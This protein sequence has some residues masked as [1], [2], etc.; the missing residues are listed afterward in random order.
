MFSFTKF[1]KQHST[2]TLRRRKDKAERQSEE[3]ESKA[4]PVHLEVEN[5]V[6]RTRYVVLLMVARQPTANLDH[7]CIL[8]AA[9]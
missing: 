7:A 4:D 5:K 3:K 1:S 2:E 9:T 6:Y 8:F